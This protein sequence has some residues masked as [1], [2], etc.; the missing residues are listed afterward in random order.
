MYSSNNGGSGGGCL[1][2][3]RWWGTCC[4]FVEIVVWMEDGDVIDGMLD[5]GITVED[6][7][8]TNT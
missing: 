8:C 3:M 4:L 2:E 1:F 7:I 5:R 6:L